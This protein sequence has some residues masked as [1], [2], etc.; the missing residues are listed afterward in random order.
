ML[1][2]RDL[3]RMRDLQEAALPDRVRIERR[4]LV[5]DG[6]GGFEE[7][8]RQTVAVNVPARITPAA[9]LEGLGQLSRPLEVA[10]FTVRLPIGT[11]VAEDDYIVLE[12][13]PNN[14]F[15]VETIKNPRSW[16]TIMTVTAEQVR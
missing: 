1:N 11:A 3:E 2:A 6:F 4:N 9:T 10:G 14:Q 16:S 15:L 7:P 13:D 8:N 5:S 12:D